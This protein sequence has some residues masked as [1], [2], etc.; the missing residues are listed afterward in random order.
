M[1]S[2]RYG[3]GSVGPEPGTTRISAAPAGAPVTI[4]E[5]GTGK[6][7]EVPMN[8]PCVSAGP[9]YRA[10]DRHGTLEATTIDR[11]DVVTLGDTVEGAMVYVQDPGDGRIPTLFRLRKVIGGRPRRASGAP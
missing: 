7:L 5:P 4:E 2:T 9:K 11:N 1:A 8:T 3:N 10:L 6:V